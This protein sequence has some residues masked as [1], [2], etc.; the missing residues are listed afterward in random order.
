MSLLA[1][2]LESRAMSS[3]IMGVALLHFGL[4]LLGL[5]SIPCPIREVLG[6]P[7][8]GC[9]LSR[10]IA[11]LIHGDWQTSI[12]YHLFAPVFLIA[13]G[14]LV[15][16]TLAPVWSRPRL[17]GWIDK[18]ES[19]TGISCILS[20]GLVVYWLIRLLFF[21]EAFISLVIG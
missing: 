8:P 13:F 14:L 4:I 1:P 11:A 7:C 12:R 6:L 3:A 9:G 16:A 2:I 18:L 21:R 10:G 5:P 17:I 15:I 20:M 19:G